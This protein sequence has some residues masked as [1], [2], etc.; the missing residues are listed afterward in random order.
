MFIGEV[1]NRYLDDITAFNLWKTSLLFHNEIRI[2]KL[3]NFW[4]ISQLVIELQLFEKLVEL[5]M[6][7]RCK[8][9]SINHLKDL[10]VLKIHHANAN[11]TQEGINELRKLEVIHMPNNVDLINLNHLKNIIELD[12][13]DTAI[14]LDGI[15]ECTKLKKL[16]MQN[17]SGVTDLNTF[18]NLEY[19]DITNNNFV[20]Q[21]GI[22]KLVNI[23]YFYLNG[24]STIININHMTK[25]EKIH[26][27][28]LSLMR[29][30]TNTRDE[31]IKKIISKTLS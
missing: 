19:L 25:L 22:N 9:S 4:F 27:N 15:R 17:S 14:D 29:F 30:F 11:L 26:A 23:K 20:N 3:E 6:S 21:T 7:N 31:R 24:N 28:P 18:V 5:N 8:I 16:I 13:S 10:K 2:S 1:F 12:L